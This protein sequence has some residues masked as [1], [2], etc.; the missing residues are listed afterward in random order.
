[1][2]KQGFHALSI[3]LIVTKTKSMTK[4][5]MIFDLQGDIFDLLKTLKRQCKKKSY[6][7]LLIQITTHTHTHTGERDKQ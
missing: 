6:Q 4:P 3:E 1:M 2:R 7:S 5:I